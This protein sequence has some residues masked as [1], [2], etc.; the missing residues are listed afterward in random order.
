MKTKQKKPKV[1]I[2]FTNSAWAGYDIRSI[3]KR[4]LTGLNLEF[5]FS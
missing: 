2:I 1:I 5:S 4:I 3:F